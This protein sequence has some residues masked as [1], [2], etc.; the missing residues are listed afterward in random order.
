M[1]VAKGEQRARTL[2][3]RGQSTVGGEDGL[4]LGLELNLSDSDDTDKDGGRR[5]VSEQQHAIR[6]RVLSAKAKDGKAAETK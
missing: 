4:G 5:A 3:R 1:A 2:S 6:E